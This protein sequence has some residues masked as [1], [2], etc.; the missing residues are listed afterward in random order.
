[1]GKGRGNSSS[2]TVKEAVRLNIDNLRKTNCIKFGTSTSFKTTWTTGASVSAKIDYTDER[3]VLTLKYHYKQKPVDHSIEI[4]EVKSNLGKGVNLYFVCPITG[5]K[6]KTIFCSY[7]SEIFKSRQAYVNRLYYITQ[8][9]SKEQ[10]AVTR[11]N[12][13]DK[14]ID[15]LY[16]LR[17]AKEYKGIV[18]KRHKRLIRLIDKRAYLDELKSEEFMKW[19]ERVYLK[20]HY[21]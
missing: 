1:M 18:T 16:G 8:I 10:R 15:E 6:C 19:F 11:Y 2:I 5:K 3:K 4:V 20:G 17:K 9:S 21:S 14:Q 13:V 7:G 12:L